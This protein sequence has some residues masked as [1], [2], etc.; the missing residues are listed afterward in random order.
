MAYHIII[1]IYIYISSFANSRNND[2]DRWSKLPGRQKTTWISTLIFVPYL[3]KVNTVRRESHPL[4]DF[5]SHNRAKQSWRSTETHGRYTRDVGSCP[6]FAWFY[7]GVWFG[8][9]CLFRPGK[10][11]LMRTA[12]FL[13][14]EDEDSFALPQTHMNLHIDVLYVAWR[15]FTFELLRYEGLRMWGHQTAKPKA[16]II[17][18]TLWGIPVFTEIHVGMYMGDTGVSACTSWLAPRSFTRIVLCDAGWLGIS[19]TQNPKD[20]EEYYPGRSLIDAAHS[21][22]PAVRILVKISP[23]FVSG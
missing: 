4:K 7:L 23:S 9:L 19:A 15:W 5:V 17:L 10:D 22:V 1:Y 21:S 18:S 8:G 2:I 20:K 13:G 11:R 14:D 16:E 6:N 12:R 3:G